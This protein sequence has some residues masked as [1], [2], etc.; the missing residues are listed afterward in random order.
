V[1]KVFAT[2]SFGSVSVVVI[3]SVHGPL[4]ELGPSVR[5]VLDTVD[6]QGWDAVESKLFQH[7][8][9]FLVVVDVSMEQS[10]HLVEDHLDGGQFTSMGATSNKDGRTF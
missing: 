5:N 2:L 3:L 9:D 8:F 4:S 10:E 7:V 1:S 6:V